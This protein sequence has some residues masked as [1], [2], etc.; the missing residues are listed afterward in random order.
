MRPTHKT[1][2]SH[3]RVRTALAAIA[4]GVALV[5]TGLAS[6]GDSAQPLRRVHRFLEVSMSPD[7]ALVASVE[8]DAPPSGGPPQVRD[9]VIRRV[10]TG[11][12]STVAMPCG[13]VPECWPAS[14]AWAPDGAHVTF[15]LR[16]PASHARSVYS[17]AADG[18]GLAK[19]LA[20]EGT[21]TTLRYAPDGRLA[22]LAI[23]NARKEVGATEAGVPVAGDMDEAPL[24]QRIGILAGGSLHWA[25]P[26]E[27]FVYEYD[28]QPD[29]KGFIATAAPGDGDSNWWQGKLYAFGIDATPG[30]ILYT[31]ADIRQQITAPRVSPDGRTVAFIAG[32]MSDFGSRGGDIYTVPVSG[33][34]A[35]NVT[36]DMRA[37]ARALAWGCNARLHAELLAGDQT[38]IVD[39]GDGRRAAVAAIVWHGSESLS[40]RDAGASQA[41]PSEFTATSHESFTAAPEIEVGTVGHWHDLTNVN[42]GMAMPLRAQSLSWKSDGFD[43]QGWL[44]LPEHGNGK[45][46][47]VTRV[48]GGPAGAVLP[49]F[50]GPGLTQTML[51]RG[52]ALFLPNPR[53]SFG[54]GE[55]FTA[56]NV[57]DFGYG[58]LRDILSGIDAAIKVA[59]IDAGRLGIMGGSYGGFMTMWAV[60][61]TKRFKAGVAAAGISDWQSYYGENGIDAWMLP[62]FGASV[63]DDPAVYA[64]SSPIAF[65]RNVQT[66]TFAYVGERDIECPA[67]QTREFW[68]ALKTLGVPTSSVIYPG[69]GHALRDP[70][71]IEDAERR[72][73]A[74]F[75]RY[76][77]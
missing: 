56:A 24:E 43:V 45:L 40:G 59:P 32:I 61:Q 76:L 63:Y 3:V 39:F 50:A 22:M 44:L 58:D 19:L 7:G 71:H 17:V 26:P 5:T 29:G 21:V 15:A 48:H 25:S 37:S 16:T 74:W 54:Q 14:V 51:E 47:M 6:A 31:P 75:E 34:A 20:F 28:W 70:A 4:G 11:A 57:R 49:A 30:R 41:C 67:P 36:P 2:T 72:T 73:L 46:P 38:Q 64:R 77:Q 60:T 33:G 8:G 53:G 65:I 12:A 69:E 9:L 1:S 23:A 66:P 27:L 18:S 10:A 62:Y 42:A 52:Y 13:R 35:T 68:H 55:R